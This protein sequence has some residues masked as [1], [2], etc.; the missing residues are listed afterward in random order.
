MI[1]DFPDEG[2]GYQ[3]VYPNL[4][5][6]GYVTS[7]NDSFAAQVAEN[8]IVQLVA[9]DDPLDDPDDGGEPSIERRSIVPGWSV[10][11]HDAPEL[12]KRAVPPPPTNNLV[13]QAGSQTALKILSQ[14]KANN[15]GGILEDVSCDSKRDRLHGERKCTY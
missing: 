6:Q 7:I 9:L 13:R 2:K 14:G 5:Y 12:R 8:S 4:N 1:N 3:I 10:P 15:I 11:R